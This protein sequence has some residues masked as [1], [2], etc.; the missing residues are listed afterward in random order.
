[1]NWDFAS[2]CAD[3]TDL[4][5]CHYRKSEPTIR[6]SW[7]S[8]SFCIYLLAITHLLSLCKLLVSCWKRSNDLY[9]TLTEATERFWVVVSKYMQKIAEIRGFL[10]IGIFVS[11]YNLF[12]HFYSQICAVTPVNVNSGK[13]NILNE[14]FSDMEVGVA[15]SVERKGIGPLTSRR[16]E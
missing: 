1:M 3:E 13:Q 8:A 11:F 4:K 14:F 12:I 10:M 6:M 7:F 16:L 5:L 2:N 9:S 15:K